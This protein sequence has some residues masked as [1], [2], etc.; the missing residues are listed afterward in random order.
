MSVSTFLSFKSKKKYLSPKV[1]QEFQKKSTNFLKKV[2]DCF[3][4]SSMGCTRR[5]FNLSLVVGFLFPKPSL[6]F[7]S[8]LNNS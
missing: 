6:L 1:S 3:E 4:N 2:S 5:A 7:Y 8:I